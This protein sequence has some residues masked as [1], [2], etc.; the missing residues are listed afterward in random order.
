MMCA[1]QV[2]RPGPGYRESFK[3]AIGVALLVT[4]QFANAQGTSAMLSASLLTRYP[5]GTILTADMANL[6]LA[7]VL[8]VRTQIESQF[9]MEEQAC[10]PTFF[11][12]S[13]LEDT[14]ERRHAALAKIRPI[15]IEANTFNRRMRVLERD[16]ALAEKHAMLAAQAP[17]RAKDQQLKG[18]ETAQK[19][20][21][22]AQKL[23]A[24]Q[25][26]GDVN[27]ANA[28][29]RVEEHAANLRRWQA[30][31]VANA[32]GRS[33]NVAAYV[34]KTKDAEAR[35]RQVA[36]SKME[37]VPTRAVRQ[38]PVLPDVAK[39]SLRQPSGSSLSN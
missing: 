6:A 27:A 34:Q 25:D 11:A 16:N 33:A 30:E 19:V 1:L 35:Q 31:Q 28:G 36:A 24:Q 15:E 18:A 20:V 9:A 39:D 4:A 21:D 37:K 14:K 17:Q 5:A 29:K 23:T 38:A 26:A 8:T 32:P 2:G 22:S 7:Q 10:Y 13:C 12:S 3:R